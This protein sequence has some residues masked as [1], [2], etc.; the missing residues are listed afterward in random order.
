LKTIGALGIY[1][2]AQLASNT[3]HSNAAMSP[4]FLQLVY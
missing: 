4:F 1:T 2:G 3:V